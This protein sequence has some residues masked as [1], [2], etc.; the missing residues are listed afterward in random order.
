MNS[1]NYNHLRAVSNVGRFRGII[2]SQQDP[3]G[4]WYLYLKRKEKELPV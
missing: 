3:F 4:Q 2:V 1:Q